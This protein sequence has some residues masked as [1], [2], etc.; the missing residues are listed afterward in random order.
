MRAGEAAVSSL[1][2]L[3]FLERTAHAAVAG[4]GGKTH[5][6]ASK[7]KACSVLSSLS[8]PSHSGVT[9]FLGFLA[10][11]GLGSG[12]LIVDLFPEDRML[13]A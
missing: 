13:L 6:H 12:L 10:F 8:P 1:R 7:S 4:N 5:S 2:P 11:G 9:F 3:A